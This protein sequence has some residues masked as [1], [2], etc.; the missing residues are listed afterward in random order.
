MLTV[1]GATVDGQHVDGS[2]FMT[3]F[4]SN[5]VGLVLMVK[6]IDKAGG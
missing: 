3:T 6:I 1:T 4:V 5:L 2:E